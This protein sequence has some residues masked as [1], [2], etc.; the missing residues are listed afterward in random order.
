MISRQRLVL[1]TATGPTKAPLITGRPRLILEELARQDAD[2]TFTGLRRRLGIHPQ[3]LTRELRRLQDQD[4]VEHTNHGYRLRDQAASELTDD[5]AHHSTTEVLRMVLPPNA[6]PAQ[7]ADA[8]AGR[9]FQDL[10]W[11]GRSDDPGEHTLIWLTEGGALVRIRLVGGLL[12]VEAE[13]PGDGI[14]SLMAAVAQVL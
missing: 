12:L 1:S 10:R 9:W 4:L 13:A 8:L 2:I 6:D 5:Q 3:A 14:A 11:Y 7:L